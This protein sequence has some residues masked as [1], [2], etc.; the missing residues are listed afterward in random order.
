MTL[1]YSLDS[2]KKLFLGHL[3]AGA[4][5][6]VGVLTFWLVLAITDTKSLEVL[7]PAYQAGICLSSIFFMSVAYTRDHN[8]LRLRTII[9]YTIIVILYII[10]YLNTSDC[11]SIVHVVFVIIISSTIG[12]LQ[13]NIL[14]SS[15]VKN[16]LFF[17]I[18]CSTLL[19][20][21]IVSNSFAILAP[22]L[23]YVIF[24]FIKSKNCD[25]TKVHSEKSSLIGPLKTLLMQS[26]FI[27]LPM[28]DVLLVKSISIDYY[29]KYSAISKFTNG[30]A[31][32][33]FSR[34]QMGILDGLIPNIPKKI[35]LFAQVCVVL[36]S[37]AT[38]FIGDV[39]QIFI[40]CCVLSLQIN[41][42]SMY[43]RIY[44]VNNN[45]NEIDIGIALGCIAAYILYVVYSPLADVPA[46]GFILML[47]IIYIVYA[48]RY[49]NFNF[50]SAKW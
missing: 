22:L 24:F 10:Y 44:I 31:L 13:T 29:V 33:L 6:A 5:Q 38:L 19:P 28:F 50:V 16:L 2:I 15:N 25:V 37:I 43:A 14:A 49:S 9:Y 8:V 4:P 47:T 34:L 27:I 12:I 3:F 35:F 1:N 23:L 42:A 36:I 7:L 45:I 32:F 20:Y 39:M 17:N 26:P 41:L 46:V 11:L 48:I 21:L 40:M 18:A 30:I